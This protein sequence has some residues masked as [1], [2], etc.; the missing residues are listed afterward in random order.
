MGIHCATKTLVGKMFLQ[1]FHNVSLILGGTF[2]CH[3]R[4]QPASWTCE[5]EGLAEVVVDCC[6][7]NSLPT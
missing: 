7:R 4:F 5:L 1:N 2:S 6:L 3:K